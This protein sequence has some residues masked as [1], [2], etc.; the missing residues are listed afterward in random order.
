MKVLVTGSNG[1]LGQK[2]T[3]LYLQQTHI[4]L[5]ATARGKN[6]YHHKKGYTY[7]ELDITNKAEVD[8]VFAL[9]KPDVVI[10]TAAMTNVDA[11]ELDHE[12][13]DA[14][15]VNGVQNIVSACNTVDAHLIHLS[16]DFIF[17]GTHGPLTEI[18]TPEP[19]SYY[20][21]SKLKG[22]HLVQ[23]QSQSWAILRTVLVYGL[24][25]DMSRSNIVLWVKDSLENG[26][27]IHVVGD[28]FRT[29]TLA[30]DLAMGCALA[31]AK[32]AKGIYH[33]SGSEFMSIFDIAYRVADYWKLDKALLNISS[34]EGIKQPAKRP[35]ITG[36]NITKA[37][38]ELGYNP[39]S[40]T[41]G[42]TIIDSQLK[43]IS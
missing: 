39:N 12:A 29:P 11:C 14:L 18:E 35:P 8:A 31:A 38:E 36:F 41:Q 27:S 30:E 32:K 6:R 2:L 4:N 10:H 22:E 13:C 1:L 40:L 7:H 33:I 43:N 17:N 3:D 9:Y 15:N 37:K 23:S 5:I 16:T 20:G 24:V 28:Q 25:N 26:K 21:H 34:S 19:L 42:L